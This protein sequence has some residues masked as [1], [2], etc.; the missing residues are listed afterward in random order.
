MTDTY[1]AELRDIIDR[2]FTAEHGGRATAQ[3]V[4]NSVHRDM[5][6]HLVDFL[7]GKGL[8]AQVG[9]YFRER[10][11]EGLPKRPEANAEGEHV[12]LAMLSVAECTHVYGRYVSRAEANSQQA[13]KVREFCFAQHGIDVAVHVGAA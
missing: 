10:D 3:M 1:T 8:R 11:A 4:H 7:V 9:A 5:P 12:Q 6:D 2:A 13:E